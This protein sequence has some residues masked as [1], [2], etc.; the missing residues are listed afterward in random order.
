MF[1]QNSQ[2]KL[3]A[4]KVTTLEAMRQPTLWFTLFEHLLQFSVKNVLQKYCL[5]RTAVKIR[6]EHAREEEKSVQIYHYKGF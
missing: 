3:K 4:D 5:H 6:V 2:Q 1:L